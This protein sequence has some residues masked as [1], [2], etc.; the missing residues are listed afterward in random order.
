MVA[1]NSVEKAGLKYLEKQKGAGED[2]LFYQVS[3][4]KG[5]KKIV[6]WSVSFP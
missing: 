5:F 3:R 6:F 4:L 1:E 2:F